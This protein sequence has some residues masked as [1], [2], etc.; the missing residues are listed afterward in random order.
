MKKYI[1][2]ILYCIIFILTITGCG[3]QN[4]QEPV[5]EDT[6]IT[7]ETTTVDGQEYYLL[8]SGEDL[9]A[10]GEVCPLSGNYMLANDITMSGEWDPLGNSKNPFTGIFDGN[11]YTIYDL[12]AAPEAN[13]FFGVAK[14]A[15]IRNVVLENA[16]F[17]GFFPMVHYST[18]TEIEGCSIN[19][20]TQK[21]PE[22]S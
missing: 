15:V 16:S 6:E 11:G 18:G 20:G 22:H 2:S 7:L 13:G 12:T 4:S 17:D 19:A 8:T 14:D 3:A 5:P 10:I 9:N 21:Q 1:F